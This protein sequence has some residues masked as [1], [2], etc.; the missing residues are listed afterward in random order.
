M[1]RKRVLITGASS[2]IGAATV[3]RMAAQG[4]TVYA[5]ARRLDRLAALERPGVCSLP[6]D[7]ADDGSIVSAVEELAADGGL[8]AIVNNAGY[9][10]Y[11]AVEDVPLAEA[12][13]QFEVNLFGAARL[14][15]LA[16]PLL[17]QAEQPRIV[18]ISSVGGRIHE[19]FGAWYHATKFALEG[20]SDCLRLE[21]QP[22][23]SRSA[24]CSQAA[25]APNGA[26]LPE[27]AFW[28]DRERACMHPGHSATRPCWTTP[29]PPGWHP[30]PR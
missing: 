28:N 23:G 17:R 12:R 26:P 20:F 1:T 5:A 6:L 27:A 18:N 25:F 19:P 13:Q 15:Q 4:W 30:I 24:W 16:L 10:S 11:G 14:I 7:L 8:S 29:S 2:G 21:L 3:Q 22:L 9:G